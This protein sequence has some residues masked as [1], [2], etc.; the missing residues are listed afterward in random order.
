MDFLTK[1]VLGGLRKLWAIP[2]R[3][4]SIDTR[5]ADLVTRNK[6]LFVTVSEF[7]PDLHRSVAQKRKRNL[8]LK[9]NSNCLLSKLEEGKFDGNWGGR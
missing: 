9:P 8:A 4:I 1:D 2:N 6:I 7:K 5:Q 3:H